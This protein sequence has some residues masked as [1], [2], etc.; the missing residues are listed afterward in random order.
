MHASGIGRYGQET[1]AAV[2]LSGLEAL[3]NVAKY[4]GA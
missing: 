1:E 4:A 3:Q 2:Y